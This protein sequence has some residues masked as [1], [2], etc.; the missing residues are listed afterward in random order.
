MASTSSLAISCKTTY[1]VFLSFRGIETHHNFTSHLC[2]ALCRKNITTFIDDVLERGEGISPALMKAIEESKISVVIFS[3]NYASSRWCLD[4]LV[5]IIDCE[6]KLGRKVLPIFYRVNP[7]DVRKQ[8]GKF[9][10]AFGK[11]KENSKHSLDVVEKWRTALMEAGNLSGWVSSDSRC[12]VTI[13]DDMLE[14]HDLIA[15]MGQDIARRKGIILCNSNDICDML[16]STNNKANEAVEGLLLNMSEIGRLYLNDSVFLRMPNLRLLKFYRDRLNFTEFRFQSN[17]LKSLPKKLSLLH[18]EKYPFKSLPLNFSMENLVHLIMPRSEVEEL[19]NGSTC[20]PNLKSLDLTRSKHLKIVPDFSMMTSL[21]DINF[22]GCESLIEIPSSIQCLKRLDSLCLAGCAKLRS[23]TQMPRGIKFLNFADSGVE[24]W[25]PSSIQYLENLLV[26][27]TSDCENLRS[28][29][30]I[31]YCNT[32]IR[33]YIS[34]CP[35]LIMSPQI[36]ESS[37]VLPSSNYGTIE[38]D[39][40]ECKKL[41]SLPNSTC[42]LKRLEILNLNGCSYLEKLPP[43]YGL[44]SLKELLLDGTALV[45]IPPDTASLSSL[46]RLSLKNCK[47]LQKSVSTSYIALIKYREE[48]REYGYELNFCNCLNLDQNARGTI[49]ADALRRI[50]ELAIARCGG[51]EIARPYGAFYPYF[52]V[53][54]P[55]GK[56][57]EW[58]S[59]EGPVN[60]IETLFPPGCFN[61]MFLG[62]VFCAIVEFKDPGFYVDHLRLACGSYFGNN[63]GV[64]DAI[65]T[66]EYFDLEN[67]IESDHV[68]FW[69]GGRDMSYL[70]WLKQNC[71]MENEATF[72]LWPD[73][74]GT[75]YMTKWEVKRFGFHLLY[76]KVE[77]NKCNPYICREANFLEQLEETTNA[78][79]KRSREDFYS[80]NINGNQEVE[81]HPKRRQN[82]FMEDYFSNTFFMED[83]FSNTQDGINYDATM[84][85]SSSSCEFAPKFYK[86][87]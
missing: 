24:E 9:G 7:S 18:W 84:V 63:N 45:E 23:L 29:P 78:N 67:T 64:R 59:C 17:Y 58:L 62:F 8:T 38:L 57:P 48:C 1:D 55:G 25:S 87:L 26:L 80:S 14:M 4:E 13:V 53:G 34:F 83:Y 39:L 19:W 50:K 74:M 82:F 71:N 69:Y 79:N 65:S 12:L 36:M 41:N 35:N 70:D 52:C 73:D 75:D 72:F 44:C 42:E 77:L 37:E 15:E 40:S 5:K 11:V 76:D 47:R 60:S 51:L 16:T 28:L 21:E 81:T 22:D 3:E 85:P 46:R 32:F 20:L 49:I 66:S 6:K 31:I 2:A 68:F 10:E 30:R 27:D 86:F 33:L 54:L 56:I 61:N 43:L